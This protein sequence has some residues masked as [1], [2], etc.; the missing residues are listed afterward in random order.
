LRIGAG[1]GPE[2]RFHGEIDDARVYQ[3]A[4]TPGE[5]GVLA[6][7]EPVTA[8]AAIVPEK[9]SKA[10]A[11][12]MRLCFLDRYA[13]ANMQ[14][15]WRDLRGLRR[16]RERLVESFPTVM[17]MQERLQPRDTFVLVRGASDKP[18]ENASRWLHA[19]LPFLS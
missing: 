6:T 11:D 19:S 8:I 18:G 3:R 5:T 2:N 16:E 7:R 13:P 1:G 17:V 12:K 10:Q 15:A 4:L 14:E 9:R